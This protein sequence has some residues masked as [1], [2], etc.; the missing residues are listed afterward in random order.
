MDGLDSVI[1]VTDHVDHCID[2]VRQALMC[3]ADTTLITWN[4][5]F[6]DAEPDFY[7]KHQCRNFDLIHKWSKKHE[8]NMEEEFVRDP[9][10]LK[11]IKFG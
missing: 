8:V 3:H 7:A 4:G 1:S 11:R 6:V 9:E 2:M 10:A 5:T